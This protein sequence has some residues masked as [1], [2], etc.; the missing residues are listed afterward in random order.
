MLITF[1][2]IKGT[3]IKTTFFPTIAFD[4]FNVNVAFTPGSGEKR[5]SEYLERFEEAIWEVNDEIKEEYADSNDF[6][7]FAFRSVGS[8]FDGEEN[9]AHAGNVSVLMRDMEG[10]PLST[11]EIAS[12]VRE[13]LVKF[14]RLQN[15]P[16]EEG[17]D[18]EVLY[19]LVY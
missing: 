11:F 4:S 19:Q 6:V 8:A 16:L 3:L 18:G 10:A 13:K 14:L 1:G 9:G 5:T 17:I 15:I 7:T 2:M 12:R